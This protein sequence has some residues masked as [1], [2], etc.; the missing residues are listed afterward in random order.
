M[1]MFLLTTKAAIVGDYDGDR[2]VDLVD[3]GVWKTKYLA[4]Q[5]TLVEF[6]VWKTAYLK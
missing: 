1:S 4:G 6:G 3:F 5:S 2:D